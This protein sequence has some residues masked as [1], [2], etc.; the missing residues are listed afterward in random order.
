MAAPVVH[1][2]LSMDHLLWTHLEITTKCRFLDFLSNTLNKNLWLV[3][4]GN[5]HFNKLPR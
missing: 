1:L 4:P 5:L 3:G 2:S